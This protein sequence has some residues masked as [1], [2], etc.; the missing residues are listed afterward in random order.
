MLDIDSPI[1]FEIFGINLLSISSS[2][3]DL[4]IENLVSMDNHTSTINLVDVRSLYRS[5]H[6]KSLRYLLKSSTRS[7]SIGTYPKLFVN[8]SNIFKCSKL[9]M[10]EVFKNSESLLRKNQDNIALIVGDGDNRSYLAE[11][12]G[13]YC[14]KIIKIHDNV[15]EIVITRIIS[16]KK[17]NYIFTENLDTDTIIRIRKICENYK[18]KCLVNIWH[19]I[20]KKHHVLPTFR[21]LFRKITDTVSFS[22]LYLKSKLYF[23]KNINPSSRKPFLTPQ[24]FYD[25]RE[26]FKTILPSFIK[27]NNIFWNISVFTKTGLKRIFD[28]YVTL[29]AV[30][31]LSPLL[32]ITA[33]LVKL[34][35]KGPIFFT[36]ERV[37]Y[38]GKPFVMY[39][40]RSMSTNAEKQLETLNKENESDGSVLFKMKNDPRITKV[41]KIIRK[42]SIDELPQLINV[43]KGEMSI[44]GPRPAL[45]SE[46]SQYFLKDRKR[47]QTKPGLTCLWQVNGRSDLSFEQ[48]VELDLAYLSNKNFAKDIQIVLKTI[49]AVISG[50]GAY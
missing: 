23:P 6:S 35:S 48:Q 46:V 22:A 30:T 28:L 2:K 33:M 10:S 20:E 36:Q 3:L 34:E 26:N 44:V 38:K 12:L 16:D 21:K 43:I 42:L 24:E 14:P 29:V 5:T 13:S 45:P 32:I 40:F 47:L 15:P 1:K 27:H 8:L 41:G 4:Y 9:K 18:I 31:L 25:Q 50:K 7:I 19:K 11:N 39:K 17:Y 49:P 37:G